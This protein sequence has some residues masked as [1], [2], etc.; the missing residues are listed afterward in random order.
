MGG[1]TTTIFL[2]QQLELIILKK[3]HLSL[4]N[5]LL[6]YSSG[7][8]HTTQKLPLY[9]NRKDG[10]TG[11]KGNDGNARGIKEIMNRTSFTIHKTAMSDEMG[12]SYKT[13][14]ET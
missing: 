1:D 12:N 9:K 6:I 10:F 2:G 8:L 5:S 11:G 3:V 4:W 13:S 7:K 14:T